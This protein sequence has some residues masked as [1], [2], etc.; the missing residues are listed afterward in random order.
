MKRPVPVV[1]S[2][3]LLGLFAAFQLLCAA[4]MAFVGFLAI[5]KKLP[6]PPTTTPFSPSF[7]PI[8][9]LGVSLFC[10]GLAVWLILTLIGLIRLRSWARY[11][12]LVIAGLMAGFGGISMVASFAMPFLMQ[13]LPAAP[14]RIATDPGTLR[15]IFFVTGAIYGVV[16]ALGVALLVYFNLAKTR[17][18]F[19]LSAPIVAGPPNTSTGRPRPTAITVISWIYLISGPI[20]LLY[21]FLPFPTFLFGFILS[22]LTAHCVYAVLGMLTFAVGYGLFR[23]RNEARIAIFALFILCPINTA[24]LLTPWGIR[25][26]RAYMDAFSTS[27]YGGQYAVPNPIA[28]PG[29]VAFFSVLGMA[30]YGLILWLLHRHR[31]AFTPAPPA[32]PMPIHSQPVEGLTP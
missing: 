22:G 15:V 30:A 19:L 26:F 10:A 1:L 16:T 23:L 3:I 2:A 17:A 7:Q 4:M 6:V 5:S 29:A 14:G 13:G 11:S 31:E 9:F 27:M 12:L 32:P 18:L 21:V 28:S 8:L 20:C 25:Q 24:V